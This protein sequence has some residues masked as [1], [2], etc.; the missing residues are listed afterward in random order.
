MD[1]KF[2]ED[3]LHKL[4][5]DALTYAELSIG[6]YMIYNKFRAKFLRVGNNCLRNLLKED[7]DAGKRWSN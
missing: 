4:F 1:D 7:E 5:E 6:D 2:I 3:E